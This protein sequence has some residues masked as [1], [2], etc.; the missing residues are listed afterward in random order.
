MKDNHADNAITSVKGVSSLVKDYKL[1]SLVWMVIAQICCICLVAVAVYNELFTASPSKLLVFLLVAYALSAV[2]LGLRLVYIVNRYMA[3]W[4]SL[5]R[6]DLRVAQLE[7]NEK[8]HQLALRQSVKAHEATVVT[9][10]NGDVRVD[11]EFYK[12][13]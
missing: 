11:D 3:V 4:Q 2:A 9:V 8:R 12:D 10:E 5:R 7:A 6:Y 13:A 1:Y